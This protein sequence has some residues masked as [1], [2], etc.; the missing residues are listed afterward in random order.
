MFKV[1]DVIQHEAGGIKLR[2]HV[3]GEFEYKTTRLDNSE[4][5]IIRTDNPCYQ[6]STPPEDETF[7]QIGQV[8][9][10]REGG[11]E[12]AIVIKV[13]PGIQP[14]FNVYDLITVHATRGYDNKM[15]LDE[16]G[17]RAQYATQDLKWVVM[18]GSPKKVAYDFLS[19]KA[20]GF[21]GAIRDLEEIIEFH[22]DLQSRLR[23]FEVK[24]DHNNRSDQASE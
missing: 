1:G 13:T 19:K 8:L 16:K 2:I 3:V 11:P 5:V 15:Q 18:Y 21:R 7:Y 23:L 12:V 10:K 6:L 24:G 17:V 20:E 14:A 9:T 4:C 22:E